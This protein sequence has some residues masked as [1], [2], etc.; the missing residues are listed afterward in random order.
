MPKPRASEEIRMPFFVWRVGQRNKVFTADGRSNSPPV[1]RHSLGT[2]NRTEALE[3]LRQLDARMAVEHGLAERMI[4][5]ASLQAGLSLTEGVK[6]YQ[7]HVCRPQIAG[8]ASDRTWK[9]YRAVFDKF[10]LFC[11]RRGIS[12]WN[13]I[14]RTTVLSYGA[15]LSHE[16][17]SA[18]T[19]YLE[20][21]VLKQVNKLLCEEEHLPQSCHIRLR[22]T[23]PE[24]DEV[25][26]WR[27]LEVAA[28][29]VH[30]Q[31]H[32]ELRWLHPVL[33]TLA[34]TGLRI[35]ELASLRS[36]DI[37]FENNLVRLTD[38]RS[39]RK[40]SRGSTRTLKGK[41][42]RSFPIHPDLRP[43]L[44]AMPR[45]TDGRLFHG[46]LGG[47][48][49]PDTIRRVLI[50]EVLTPLKEQFPTPPGAAVGFVD[51]R[52]HSFRHY[53]CSICASSGQVTE[54]TLMSW[55]GHRES[56]MIRRYFQLLDQASQRQMQSLT[57]IPA[58][59]NVP[60]AP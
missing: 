44:L 9:R 8:G 43:V 21:I 6:L 49:K 53:F 16:K 19:Q 45:S 42:S 29:L 32:T 55:L 4:L 41:R 13:A 35:S 17:Y 51:G 37:D 10:L 57:F 27:P 30:C 5:D 54:Q 31:Q 24:N 50:R 7:A 2:R 38:E 1:G 56:S 48:I 40:R 14:T 39:S 3:L 18:A 59:G 47:K 36:S 33:A 12:T 26:C 46:P 20:M 15:H 22:L 23:K 28:M 11:E 25:Y 34:H 58:A 52:L 60:A